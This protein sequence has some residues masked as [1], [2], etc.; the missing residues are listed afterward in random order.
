MIREAKVEQTSVWP[1]GAGDKFS[2]GLPAYI[3]FRLA[4]MRRAQSVK[5]AT[6]SGRETP[7]EKKIGQDS[8]ICC[9]IY[10]LKRVCMINDSRDPER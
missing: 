8:V 1:P 2:A 10:T 6:M 7:H 4:H 5:E 9:K 3:P